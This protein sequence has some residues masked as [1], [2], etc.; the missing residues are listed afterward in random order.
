VR[1]QN[2]TV[3]AGAPSEYSFTLSRKTVKV[4]PV[5][6]FVINQGMFPHDF[7][8]AGKVTSV[9]SPGQ[10]GTLEVTLARA[11]RYPY[12]CTFPGHAAAGMHG[13]LRVVR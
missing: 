9:I 5:F 6:F 2:V 13:V 10:T 8:I 12:R 3:T 4:G 7:W 11:G 1:T